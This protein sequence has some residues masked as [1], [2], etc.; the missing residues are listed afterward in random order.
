MDALVSQDANEE[1]MS[2]KHKREKKELQAKIQS[3]KKSAP[4]GD[5]KKKREITEEISRLE[6]EMEKRHDEETAQLCGFNAN[7]TNVTDEMNNLS[8][9]GE[10]ADDDLDE[11]PGLRQH[12]L[13]KA[14][15]RRDKK[16]TILKER[17]L[18]ISEQEVQNIHGARNVETETI[19]KI[20][21]QRD[22]MIYEIPSDGNC[23][24]CAIEH[25]LKTEE[26]LGAPGVNELRLMTSKFLR[27]NSVDFLPYLSHPD[28]GEM[29]T[30]VQ[31]E[32]YCD[33]VANT[34]AWG[35]EVEL[36]A[37]SHLLKC[38]FEIIQS[39]GPAIVIGGEYKNG[40]QIVLTYHRHMYGLGEH[41]NSV[42]PYKTEE[43]GTESIS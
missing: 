13:T 24:Y 10:I 23:L 17:E 41:Y 31:F 27:E 4:K 20:L 21:K 33:Q 36:R 26:G 28:T 30:E 22:L 14:Q 11:V 12:R 15:R 8:V 3:L 34:P 32:D 37:L 29:L 40:K 25:Q 9:D 35:G 39:T 42:Q 16:A 1:D 2:Q 7:I 38:R 19:K 6:L 43:N 5:K 18:R